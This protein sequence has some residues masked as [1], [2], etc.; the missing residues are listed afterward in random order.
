MRPDR[1]RWFAVATALLVATA[2]TLAG[3][4][5]GRVSDECDGPDDPACLA[6]ETAELRIAGDYVPD[7]AA[8][9]AGSA[10]V[11]YD[12]VPAW[13]GGAHCSGGMTPGA[14]ELSTYLRGT[15]SGISSVGGYSCRPNN[16]NTSKMSVHGSGR[17]LDIM[18]PVEDDDADNG[19]GDP[20]ANWLI[21]NST[22][23]GVQYLGWDHT[24]WSGSRSTG[25]VRP[26]TGDPHVNHIHVE[27]T[28]EGAAR[29]TR[30]F[31]EGP[32]PTAPLLDGVFVSSDFPGGT[33]IEVASGAEVRGC[34]TYTNRGSVE[35]LPGT[36]KLGTTEPRDHPSDYPGSDW[37]GS[38][39]L[40]T[41]S[42]PTPAGGSGQFCF[43]LRGAAAPGTRVERF[44]LVHEAFY[45]AADTGGVSDATNY[46]TVV[47]VAAPPPAAPPPSEFPEMPSS[48]DAGVRSPDASGSWSDAGGSTGA[49]L[50]SRRPIT[51]SCS[52]APGASSRGALLAILATLALT[53]S[54][55]RRAT[56]CERI[57]ACAPRS[58]GAPRAP[59]H[60]ALG[61]A[62]VALLLLSG[63]HEVAARRRVG[64]GARASDAGVPFEADATFANHDTGSTPTGAGGVC[65]TDADCPP[66]TY[67]LYGECDYVDSCDES[68]AHTRPVT[69]HPCEA[70][71]CTTLR[72]TE[73][74]ACARVTTGDVCGS[75]TTTVL[76]P[77][78]AFTS[79]CDESGTQTVSVTER[80]CAE[81]VCQT[82]PAPMTTRACTRDTD[83]DAC[84][85]SSC[86]DVCRAG[87]CEPRC[88][89][90]CPC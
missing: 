15:F 7:P 9:A 22:L 8:L 75:G 31:T 61:C 49:P 53:V 57:D 76:G 52:A 63:C 79:S 55:R 23:I 20:I 64:A 90:G 6:V 17:A 65:V 12:D 16:N 47:T 46:L 39:R 62:S 86:G 13:D 83:G 82:D 69:T 14:R 72:T 74:E 59:R 56:A 11:S 77:C 41:I 54:R 89:V 45:W 34:L 71:R 2:A 81:G 51:P 60:L 30:F 33:T 48:A 44:S 5:T 88:A 18:I 35:W 84:D 26:L 38:T 67:G 73:S 87:S 24:Q 37:L 40:A 58:H 32:P 3:C 27:L 19:V 80:Y 68:G 10:I 50:A 36:T 43:S 85:R 70:G 4:A 29:M 28:L 1:S 42:A 25:R 66:T 21:A 78:T